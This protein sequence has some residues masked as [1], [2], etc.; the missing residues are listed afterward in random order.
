MDER[1][2]ELIREINDTLKMLHNIALAVTKDAYS[3]FKTRRW[4]EPLCPSCG[5]PTVPLEMLPEDDREI[6]VLLHPDAH[7]VCF[8]CRL[9]FIK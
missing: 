2:E 8:N 3:D 5:N 7:S 6:I 9:I 4:D 1:W